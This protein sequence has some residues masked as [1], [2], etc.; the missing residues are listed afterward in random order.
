MG[1][2]N[3]IA[4]NIDSG[5]SDDNSLAVV[6]ALVAADTVLPFFS[7]LSYGFANLDADDDLFSYLLDNTITIQKSF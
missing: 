5:F 7:A 4:S 6:K 3:R 2:Y 1:A